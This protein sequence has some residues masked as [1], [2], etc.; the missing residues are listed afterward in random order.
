MITLY[1]NPFSPFARKVRM[2]LAYKN[3]GYERIDALDLR[4]H[5]RLLAVNPRGEVPALVDDSIVV[6]NSSD[7]VS[8]LEHRYPQPPVLPS[9]AALRV[10]ARAWERMAD[11]VLDA[12]VHDIS[13]WVWPTHRRKDRPPPGLFEAGQRDSAKIFGQIEIAL[14]SG[15][16][17]C[18]DLSI[19]EFALFPYLSSLKALGV[20]PPEDSFPRLTAWHRRLRAVPV[21]KAD[22]EDVKRL[23]KERFVDGP[24]PYEGER[25]VWRGERLEWLFRQG[26]HDW[27]ARESAEGRA[28]VPS[29]L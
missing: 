23:A 26:F 29:S 12:I 11:S 2:V 8:Y 25:V 1:D 3:L 5:A 21:V 22:L 7:I 16:F 9:D 13:L 17:L 27:W 6:V 15:G 14:G 18:G 19:A 28:V 20:I 4:Q 10:Q 24:S